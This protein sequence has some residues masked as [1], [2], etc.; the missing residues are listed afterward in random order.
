MVSSS[1]WEVAIQHREPSSVLANDLEG[2]DGSG[3]GGRLQR[4]GGDVCICVA[5]SLCGTAETNTT[6]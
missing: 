3:M 4:E 2:W 5:E 1:W 6:V